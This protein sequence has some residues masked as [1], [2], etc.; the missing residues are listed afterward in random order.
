MRESYCLVARIEV[1]IG[2]IRED[3]IQH[4]SCVLAASVQAQ[5]GFFISFGIKS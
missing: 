5:I 1:V 3:S 2:G 4:C